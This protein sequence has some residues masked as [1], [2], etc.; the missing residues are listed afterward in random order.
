MI[1]GWVL[2]RII[3]IM[4]PKK[5]IAREREER[6]PI[7]YCRASAD[8]HTPFLHLL[9]LNILKLLCLWYFIATVLFD[10]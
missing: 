1:D 4:T 2:Y 6:T 7:L 5:G 3:I 8:F 9:I 10:Q